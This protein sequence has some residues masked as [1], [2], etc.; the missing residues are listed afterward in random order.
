MTKEIADWLMWSK[1]IKDIIV[2]GIS[3]GQGMDA[4]WNK[5]A[6][7]Y[8]HCGDTI[9]AKGWFPITGEA[10]N[11]LKFVKNELFLIVNKNYSTIIDSTA[12]VGL[13]FGGLLSSYI[14]FTQPELLQGYIIIS[15]SLIWNDKSI[16]KLEVEYF[17]NHKELNKVVYVAYG[18]MDSKRWVINP[19]NEIIDKIQTRNYEGLK[20]DSRIFEGETH[21]SVFSTALTNGL[22]TLFIP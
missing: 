16:L 4:W 22:K 15:P 3:Y 11:F 9:V 19:T 8:T 18:S 7:D 17:N 1:E 5:R 6:R 21:I 2:I 12:I 13:S 14:L 20:F 10:D